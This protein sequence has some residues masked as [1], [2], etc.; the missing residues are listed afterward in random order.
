MTDK[1]KEAGFPP[2]QEEVIKIEKDIIEKAIRNT[3]KKNV[4]ITS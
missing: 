3:Y 4:R 2:R 1:L